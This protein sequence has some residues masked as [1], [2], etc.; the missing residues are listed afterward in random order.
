MRC[1]SM[2]ERVLSPSIVKNP[3]LRGQDI[4]TLMPQAHQERDCGAIFCEQLPR[5]LAVVAMRGPRAQ[6]DPLDSHRRRARVHNQLVVARTLRTRLLAIPG[7]PSI[8]PA[9]RPCGC[10]LTGHGQNRAKPVIVPLPGATFCLYGGLTDGGS[11]ESAWRACR[12]TCGGLDHP[13]RRPE[14]SVAGPPAPRWR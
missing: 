12:A 5:Q 2:R 3:T 10:R 11:T 8:A 14:S 4:T 1:H 6:H 7:R 9:G 13:A